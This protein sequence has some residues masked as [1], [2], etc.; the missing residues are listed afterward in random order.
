MKRRSGYEEII[1]S[2]S[3]IVVE[4]LHDSQFLWRKIFMSDG[5]SVTQVLPQYTMS[6]R[7]TVAVVLRGVA[8][9]A[10]YN[11]AQVLTL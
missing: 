1:I 11:V 5:F 6:C 7:T 2:R 3:S 4:V 8:P 10:L 9:R